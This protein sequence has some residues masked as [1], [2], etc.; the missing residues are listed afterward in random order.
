MNDGMN[1][2]RLCA[3]AAKK[4]RI[5]EEKKNPKKKAGGLGTNPSQNAAQFCLF[6]VVMCVCVS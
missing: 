1:D 5:E 2:E 3:K 6:P 4:A